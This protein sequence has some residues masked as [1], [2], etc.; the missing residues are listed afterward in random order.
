MTSAHSTKNT[1]IRTRKIRGEDNLLSSISIAEREEG[2][3]SIAGVI[4]CDGTD[5]EAPIWHSPRQKKDRIR[6]IQG[7]NLVEAAPAPVFARGVRGG[8]LTSAQ[9]IPSAMTGGRR[10]NRRRHA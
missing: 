6:R 7:R 1:S 2:P 3:E 4:P 10:G 5:F 8:S 9:R